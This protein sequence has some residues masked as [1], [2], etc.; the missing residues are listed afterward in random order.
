MSIA[1]VKGAT[2]GSEKIDRQ[3]FLDIN[4]EDTLFIAIGNSARSDDG[5]G[6]A[7][8]DAIKEMKNFKGKTA[9]GYQLQVEDAERLSNF[10][11]VVFIDAY[12]GEDDISFEWEKTEP[13][14]DF[15]FTTHALTP[16]AVL[17]LCQDL[18]E[19]HPQAYTLKIRGMDW[20]L[21]IGMSEYAIQNLNEA[22]TFFS[23][24]IQE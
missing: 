13:V 8:L 16:G 12:A 3:K 14:N 15:T 17:Y 5:L 6:W 1:K 18:Y 10:P 11:K 9:Y 24:M 4:Q 21:K 19:H 23:Q 7:F 22:M 2:H 20:E